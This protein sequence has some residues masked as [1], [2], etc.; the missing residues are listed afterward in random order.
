MT[1]RIDILEPISD[2]WGINSADVVSEIKDVAA[3]DPI[4]VVLNC[5]GGD[6]FGAVSIRNALH[7]HP[8]NL[9]IEVIGLAA[10]GGSLIMSIE[11]AHVTM[12][13]GTW[14]MIHDPLTFAVGNA[15]DMRE[16]ADLLDRLAVD[17]AA[18]YAR[19]M[20]GHTRAEV[21][22]LMAA[23]TWYSA[24]EALECGLCNETDDTE[25][26][27]VDALSPQ[28]LRLL[29]SYGKTP[30]LEDPA[31]PREPDLSDLLSDLQH[32]ST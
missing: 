23:E 22:D 15:A 7:S 2:W 19:R 4:H 32:L 1:T 6:L 24:D 5:P 13:A 20:T 12:R 16:T 27:S 31:P 25:D 21:R 18:M 14:A 9:S 11:H 29:A 17:M 28:T 26:A 30:K 3:D 8:A 10:S